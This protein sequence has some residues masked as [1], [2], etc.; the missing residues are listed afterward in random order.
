MTDTIRV[1]RSGL[2]A[3]RNAVEKMHRDRLF[4]LITGIHPQPMSV[5]HKSGIVWG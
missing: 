4:V 3:Q 5:L 1:P 2:H